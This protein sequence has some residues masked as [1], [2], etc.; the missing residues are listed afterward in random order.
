MAPIYKIAVIQLYPKPLAASTN[1]AKAI[2]FIRDAAAQ[3]C[4]LAVLPEYHISNWLPDEPAF[5]SICDDYQKYISA[6]QALAKELNI[7][8]VPGTIV[9]TH[10]DE[11]HN[12]AY[13]ISKNGEIL[14][15]YK[16]KNLW[17]P[18]RP[19]LTSSSHTPHVAFDTPLGKVGLLICWDL[20]FPEAFREL[21]TQGAKTIIIPTFWTMSDCNEAGLRWNPQAERVF[22]ECTLTARCFENTCCVVFANAG[23]PVGKK[24]TGDYAGLSQVAVPFVGAL[25][26]LGREEGMSVVNLDMQILED[27]E[28]NYKVRADIAQEGWHY[29]YTA[30]P[31]GQDDKAD[32]KL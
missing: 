26:K 13:F 32:S 29:G 16:K 7:C 28:D 10:G 27:A 20:A 12:V 4:D 19:H 1:H 24:T 17:H 3:K 2:S 5:K 8:V 18:E 6:Y 30:R 22:L 9:E 31:A 15:Q 23:G 11:L 14:S 25:G 21:I